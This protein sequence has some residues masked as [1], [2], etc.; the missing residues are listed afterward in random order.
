MSPRFLASIRVVAPVL[1]VSALAALIAAG[2]TSLVRVVRTAEGAQTSADAST[3]IR[4]P[5][6]EPD[7]QGVWNYSTITPLER[8][9]N[10]AGKQVLTEEEAAKLEVDT[11]RRR[12]NDRYWWDRGTKVVEDR[13]TSLIVDPPNGR[14]PPLT[15]EGRQRAAAGRVQGTDGPEQ[16][17]LS[18]RCITRTL[19]RLPEFYNNN[20]Q[21]FQAPGYVVIL[22][23][24]IHDA[25]IIPLDG[26]PH[27]GRDIRQWHGDPRGRWEGDTLV[28]DTTNF[29]DQTNFR[30]SAENLHLVE[31]FTRVDADTVLY[32]FTVDDPT[33][34]TRPWTAAIP[35]TKT[36]GPIYEYAC[37]EGNDA[38]EG[39]LSMA[40]KLEK[41]AGSR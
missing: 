34:F 6:G 30:G 26:R 41:A 1:T 15:P 36:E 21:I 28:V 37:H 18:E 8:P 9:R 19:P 31:R 39:I 33:T 12:V 16:R 35:M 25:R 20:F 17:N 27:L 4:T 3:P 29:T 32:E 11:A 2:Q 23:E 14:V 13:R 40:R 10:L 5:W 24:M 38:M 22:M 7:L